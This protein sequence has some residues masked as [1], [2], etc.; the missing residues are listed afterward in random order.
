MVD[1]LGGRPKAS[2]RAY[3]EGVAFGVRRFFD[4]T[5]R[6]WKQVAKSSGVG[7]VLEELVY[8]RDVPGV[9]FGLGDR[10]VEQLVILRAVHGEL[11]ET[12][13]DDFFALAVRGGDASFGEGEARRSVHVH[14][15]GYAG[16]NRLMDGYRLKPVTASSGVVRAR[17]VRAYA[18]WERIPERSA[19]AIFS[20]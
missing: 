2:R 17:V 16:Q 4:E 1:A 10:S 7:P 18:R 11:I 15:A 6:G 14:V 8:R 19:A 9:R 5:A 13:V 20:R 3:I 12:A